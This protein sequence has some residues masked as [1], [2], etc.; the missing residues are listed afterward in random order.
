MNK[1]LFSTLVFLSVFVSA[2]AQQKGKIYVESFERD[3]MDLTA[4]NEQY[5]KADYAIIKVTS[6]NPDDELKAYNFNFGYMASTV[7]EHNDELWVYVQRNAKMVTIS[8]QGYTTLNKYDLKTTIQ[9]GETY[10][11]VLSPVGPRVEYQMVQ[12]NINPYD[13]KSFVMIKNSEPNSQEELFGM[14]D[15]TGSVAKSLKYGTYTYRVVSDS[16]YISEGRFTLNDKTTTHVETMRLRANGAEITFMVDSDADIY[17]NGDKAASKTWTGVLKSG[18]YQVECR[19]L[20][21]R[22]SIRHITVEDTL[23]RT[24]QLDAPTPI[25]GTL[26][27]TSRPLSARINIDGTDYGLTPRNINDLLIG[28]HKITVT[29]D[30]YS[31]VSDVFEIKENQTTALELALNPTEATLMKQKKSETEELL[32]KEKENTL[33]TGTIR[34][35]NFHL[36]AGLGYDIKSNV[37]ATLGCS[38]KRLSFE[39]Y[40]SFSNQESDKIYWYTFPDM[41]GD[42]YFVYSPKMIL[43]VKMG[44]AILDGNRFSLTPQLGVRLV[45]FGETLNQTGSKDY[46]YLSNFSNTTSCMSATLSLKACYKFN[47]HFGVALTPEYILKVNAGDYYKS[48][49]DISSQMKSMAEGFNLS[50]SLIYS[51]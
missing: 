44:C 50:V 23:N 48:L 49:A 43:G 8:R 2:M 12:F 5:K 17:I 18:N 35:R 38:Y 27:I 40:Y 19:Q 10:R 24:I 32:S 4:K 26:A 30:G 31:E 1:F 6:K 21:H 20:N 25:V 9:E 37:T 39:G 41:D 11:M 45:N 29:K 34:Q 36:Y 28:N 22:S 7:E 33:K 46:Y 16:Y 15:E 42:E 51:I 3:P 13:A 47:K 14:I